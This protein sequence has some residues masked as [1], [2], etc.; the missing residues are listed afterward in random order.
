MIF[1]DLPIKAEQIVQLLRGEVEKR[2]IAFR[3]QH[4]IPE[5]EAWTKAVKQ[6][7]ADLVS[8]YAGTAVFTGQTNGESEFLLDFGWW[9]ETGTTGRRAIM[10]AEIEWTSYHKAQDRVRE[11]T[12]DF[13]KLLSFKAPL[14]L[15]VFDAYYPGD[16]DSLHDGIRDCLQTFSQH[17]RGECYLLVEFF[18]VE[19][20]GL[21][22][23]SGK[24]DGHSYQCDGYVYCVEQDGAVS[25]VAFAPIG[26]ETLSVVASDPI[27]N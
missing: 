14:K 16:H 3:Q 17:V 24:W 18:L 21:L 6:T 22:K 4:G 13:K 1:G 15:F 10:G 25:N 12:Y 9:D 20:L 26:R 7:L 2:A 11:A 23:K 19:N 27:G 5:G 8:K